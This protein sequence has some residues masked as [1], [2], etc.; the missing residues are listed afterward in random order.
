MTSTILGASGREYIQNDVPMQ[1][2]QNNT[3]AV[4][5]AQYDL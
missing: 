5:K 1:R 2:G 4:Y 3:V